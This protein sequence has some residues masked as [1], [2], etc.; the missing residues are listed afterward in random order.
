MVEGRSQ[1]ASG[2]LSEYKTKGSA[3]K[4]V[5][6]EGFQ[7]EALVALDSLLGGD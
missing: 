1:E 2:D 5:F 3:S 7:E 6:G 4:V